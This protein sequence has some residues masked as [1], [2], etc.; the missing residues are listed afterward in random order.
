MPGSKAYTGRGPAQSALE[1][2]GCM[3]PVLPPPS[4]FRPGREQ[5]ATTPYLVYPRSGQ[6]TVEITEVE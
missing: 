2:W 1:R 3:E 4:T 6:D 5:K